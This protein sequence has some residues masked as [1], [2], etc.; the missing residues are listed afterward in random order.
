MRAPSGL[1]VYRTVIGEVL[2]V[3]LWKEYALLFSNIAVRSLRTDGVYLE[4]ESVL[5]Q[6]MLKGIRPK[7]IL[8]FFVQNCSI[9]RNCSVSLENP[10]ELLCLNLAGN[11]RFSLIE[12]LGTA[13][14]AN[15]KDFEKALGQALSHIIS[16]NLYKNIFHACLG[17]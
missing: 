7:V 2:S 9:L 11:L 14:Y 5:S 4:Q 13:M 17:E 10:M 8:N 15:R 1:A 16:L 6:S 12:H 3:T